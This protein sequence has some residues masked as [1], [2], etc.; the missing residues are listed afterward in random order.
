[1]DTT[2]EKQALLPPLA[3]RPRHVH[4]ITDRFSMTNT[5]VI[6]DGHLI[7]VDPSSALNVRLT[8][9]YIQRFLRRSPAEIDL[10]VL[11]RLHPDFINGVEALRQACRAPV[12]ASILARYLIQKWHGEN[13][14]LDEQKAAYINYLFGLAL[15]QRNRPGI[16]HQLDLFHPNYERQARMVDLWLE[17]VSGLP[18]HPSWRVIASPGRTPESLCLYNPFSYELLCG[19]TV[20]TIEGGAALVRGSSNRGHLEATLTTLRTLQVY[21]L[22]PGHGRPVLS[23]TVLKNARVEW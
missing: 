21:Y 17:D 22:Y 1:M 6:D 20:A 23:P 7:V 3:Q 8:L 4:N 5:Y 10:V 11:T 16:L 9:D 19:D 14:R 2:V 13:L 12:A 18:V 15:N